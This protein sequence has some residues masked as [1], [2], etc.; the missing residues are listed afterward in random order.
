MANRRDL[1]LIVGLVLSGIAS[2]FLII[3]FST[4]HWL[5]LN[6]NYI[7]NS[8]FENLGLW[9]ACFKNFVHFRDYTKKLYNGCWWTFSEEYRPIWSYIN[10]CKFNFYMFKLDQ[11][12]IFHCVVLSILLF[13]C[14]GKSF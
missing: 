14:R 12:R 13:T 1:L 10:P 2:L 4:S 3:G 9:E 8:G 11:L 5:E 7:T 6:T